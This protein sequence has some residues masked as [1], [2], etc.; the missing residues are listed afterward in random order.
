MTSVPSVFPPIHPKIAIVGEAPGANEVSERMPFVGT[1]GQELT[2]MLAEAGINRHACY[3]GNV[4]S[5]R[6]PANDLEHFCVKKAELPKSYS[7]PALVRGK[8]LDPK[9]LP[10]VERLRSELLSVKPNLILAL[11]NTACWALLGT[12]GISKMRGAIAEST[13]LPGVKVLPTYHPAAVMRQWDLRS[14]TVIDFM[15]ASRESLFPEIKTPHREIWL[16][17]SLNDMLEYEKWYITG[18]D[19]LAFDIETKGY[20]FIT[21]VGI[22]PDPSSAIVVPFVNERNPG[23][24]YWSEKDE[25]SAWAWLKRI[26]EGPIAKMGQNGLY[27]L[28]YLR[29]SGIIVRNYLHDTMLLHHSLQ[30]ELP[31]SLDFLGS[32][33]SEEQ[34]WKLIRRRA[35]DE[36]TKRDE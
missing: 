36:I 9:Y 16:H 32:I 30:P 17:P 33:Y 10:E 19:L 11:G 4:F 1:S 2:R 12:T 21:C 34:A 35:K 28:Q 23:F 13:L 14:T 5:I 15:K 26:L 3:V 27:D 20:N 22:S 29:E 8:Y 18:S 6:P 25:L 31:K 7:H 24:H